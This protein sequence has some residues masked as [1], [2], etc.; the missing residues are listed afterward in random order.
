MIEYDELLEYATVHGHL[1]GTPKREIDELLAQKKNV[2]LDID[3]QGAV[4]V[5]RKTR[6]TSAS[7]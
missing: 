3:S 2:L 4:S 6:I 5:M 7:L 1:Y